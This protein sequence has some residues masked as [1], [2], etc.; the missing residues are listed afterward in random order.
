[1]SA[2][3]QVELPAET[4]S[5]LE[6]VARQQQRSV[7]EV[8]R[9]L[10]VRELA[11]QAPQPA[12]IEAELAGFEQLLD[13]TLW[14]LKNGAQ[15]EAQQEELV[16]LNEA[17][18]QRALKSAEKQRRQV[19]VDAYNSLLVRRAHAASLLANRG[20]LATLATRHTRP[21]NE[22]LAE[23]HDQDQAAGPKSLT[24]QEVDDYL[25]QERSNWE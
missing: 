25:R 3:I 11:A 16:Q 22:V 12:A 23:S 15:T 8:V 10:I 14:L 13:D 9:A 24:A 18:Q 5:Q 19:L 17:N 2:I 7:D 4:Y 21:L 20:L 6:D 1:M